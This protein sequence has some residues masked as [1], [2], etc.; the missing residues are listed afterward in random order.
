MDHLALAAMLD[1]HFRRGEAS[2]IEIAFVTQRVVLGGDD[3]SGWQATQL[4][5]V[6]R[7]D[8]GICSCRWPGDPQLSAPRDIVSGQAPASCL[9]SDAGLGLGEIRVRAGQDLG[10]RQLSA[11]VTQ[12]EAGQGGEVPAGAVTRDKES[13]SGPGKL[14]LVIEGP[15]DRV[16]CIRYGC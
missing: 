1:W 11:F 15:L 13:A 9:L 16:G 8:S 6:E 7:A 5:D 2:G 3:E 12:S 4:G 14:R 10:A